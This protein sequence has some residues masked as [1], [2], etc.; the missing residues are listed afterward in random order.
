MYCDDCHKD[1]QPIHDI[2]NSE[3]KSFVNN[4]RNWLEEMGEGDLVKLNEGDTRIQ[5]NNTGWDLCRVDFLDEPY[6]L[7]FVG[8]RDHG[9][10][11]M[12]EFL[13]G[14]MDKIFS[15]YDVE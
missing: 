6:N 9:E 13:D 3:F 14:S 11:K 7:R 8:S 10:G 4:N 2:I 5:F 1:H 12:Y 15:Y